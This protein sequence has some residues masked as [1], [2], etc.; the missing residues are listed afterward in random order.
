[1]LP[2]ISEAPEAASDIHNHML[3]HWGA[4]VQGMKLL[5][6][7]GAKHERYES[8]I[9][10]VSKDINT[11]N[12]ALARQEKLLGSPADGIQFD[13]FGIV[14]KNEETLL[15]VGDEVNVKIGPH[16]EQLERTTKRLE[17]EA[18]AFKAGVGGDVLAKL[19]SV[20]ESLQ[21]MEATAGRT[22]EGPTF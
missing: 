17:K 18:V 19:R 22:T 15:E 16:L 10:R 20:E 1:L 8:E 13:L 5:K 12:M 7:M 6:S 21:V 4:M 11:L 9:M 3:E 14:D 2:T